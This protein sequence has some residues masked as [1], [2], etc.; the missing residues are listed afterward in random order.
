MEDHHLSREGS[1]YPD[2]FG[3]QA[4]HAIRHQ[5]ALI[6]GIDTYRAG[7]T[8]LRNAAGDA[9]SIA[10]LLASQYGFTTMLADDRQPFTNE[11]ATLGSHPSGDPGEPA[12]ARG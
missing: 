1:A 10:E 5:L 12:P 7:F 3:T 4:E 2:G 11:A 6:V 9:L 8:P